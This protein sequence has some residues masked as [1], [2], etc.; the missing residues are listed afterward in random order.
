MSPDLEA[1][2]DAEEQAARATGKP[3]TDND[4]MLRTHFLVYKSLGGQRSEAQYVTDLYHFI[5][6][7]LEVFTMG[8]DVV[9]MPKRSQGE[10]GQP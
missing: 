9:V 3:W 8:E 4:R 5:E 1:Q 10:A 7:T 6:Y 2:L